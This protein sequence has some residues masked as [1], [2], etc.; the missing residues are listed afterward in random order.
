MTLRLQSVSWGQSWQRL[1][2]GQ[3]FR[4]DKMIEQIPNPEGVLEFM[5]L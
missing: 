2:L 4:P 5:P 1:D 3:P